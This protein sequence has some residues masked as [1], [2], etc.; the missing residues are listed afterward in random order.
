MERHRTTEGSPGGGTGRRGS[1]RGE[2]GITVKRGC[3]CWEG[4]HCEKGGATLRR[5]GTMRREEPL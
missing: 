1:H 5:G 4:C 2:R 3:H